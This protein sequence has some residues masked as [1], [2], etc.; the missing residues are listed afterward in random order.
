MKVHLDLFSGDPPPCYYKDKIDHEKKIIRDSGTYAV[1]LDLFQ[2]VNR[3]NHAAN[4]EDP[5][6]FCLDCLRRLN[7]M[8]RLGLLKSSAS[9]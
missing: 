2:F 8:G 4:M 9:L 6:E 7:I 5:D 1:S 3:W